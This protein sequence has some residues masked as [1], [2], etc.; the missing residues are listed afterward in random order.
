VWK[1]IIK[2]EGVPEMFPIIDGLKDSV[3][4]FLEGL[5]LP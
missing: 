1:V 2:N 4:K 3:A 5:S